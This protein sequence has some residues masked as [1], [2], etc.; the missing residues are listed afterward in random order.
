MNLSYSKTFSKAKFIIAGVT[1]LFLGV[2]ATAQTYRL[3]GQHTAQS[4]NL[5]ANQTV[6]RP[7]VLVAPSIDY[8]NYEEEAEPEG[9]LY[10][11]GWNS[12]RVN[13]YAGVD[14]PD[15]IDIDVR[16]FSMP[17]PGYMTSPYGYRKR[18]G[19][20]H[21]GV[22]LHVNIGDTVRAAFDG[23]VRI[24][25]YE[26]RGYG[27]YV[28]IRH[29]NDLETVYG[30]LSRFLVENDQYV[31]AGDPIA[32]AGNTGR[33]TGPHLH[34]ET[35][36]M[37]YAIN[38]AGI[39]DF[40]N[41]TTHTDV[42]TFDKRTYQR[43]RNFSPEANAAYAAEY[44]KA[45]PRRAVAAKSSSKGSGSKYTTVRKG[46]SLSKIANR[47]HTTV[48]KLCRLNGI[49]TNSTLRPGQKLRVR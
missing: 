42:Y 22:D 49:R 10:E 46:D 4:E 9:D 8:L 3:P 35:R 45:N 47:N 41:Q 40:A 20:M 33:S 26:A 18:F 11:V 25:N 5:L 24:T 43:A 14:V 44:T 28:V 7:N 39:F 36:Y 31:K 16:N 38:P 32:L 21:K 1:V 19:R 30:H 27:K 29:Y 17:H 6:S 2:G 48:K 37:G 13:C 15:H 23:R 34:F 12:N